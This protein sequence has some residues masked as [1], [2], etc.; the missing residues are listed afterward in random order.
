MAAVFIILYSTASSLVLFGFS[1]TLF[2]LLCAVVL[3]DLTHLIIPNELVIAIGAVA[4]GIL[5]LEYL[6]G[7]TL[8]IIVGHLISA[9]ISFLVY[10]SLWVVSKGR[11]IGFGDA[12]LALPL[13]LLLSPA[14]AFT[15]IVLSFWVGAAIAIT[16]LVFQKI[17]RRL[18]RARYARTRVANAQGYLTMKSEIPFAPFLIIGLWLVFFFHFDVIGLGQVVETVLGV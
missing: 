1:A 18:K 5:V 11:W 10:A 8:G 7:A 2:V 12:K 6:G 3:Y 14:G 15:M 17:Q 16:M 4:V 9:T 13:G